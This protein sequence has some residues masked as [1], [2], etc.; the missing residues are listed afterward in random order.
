MESHS[1]L[2]LLPVTKFV[3]AQAPKVLTIEPCRGSLLINFYSTLFVCKFILNTVFCS[4][5]GGGTGFIGSAL[6]YL[7]KSKGYEVTIISRM[8]G[9]QRITWVSLIK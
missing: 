4:I 7:L 3:L 5:I 8:P 2:T 6:T 1:I 9:P